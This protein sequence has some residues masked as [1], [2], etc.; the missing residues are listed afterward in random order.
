MF[1]RFKHKD[2]I[3]KNKGELLL[4]QAFDSKD[5][6]RRLRIRRAKES[7]HT[8]DYRYLLNISYDDKNW[9]DFI[10]TYSFM[11]VQVTGRNLQNII[12]G[13]ENNGI[14]LIQEFDGTVFSQ[15]EP[16]EAFIESIEII[17][18]Q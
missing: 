10:L 12:L 8:P 16:D 4:Y 1:E 13:I 3:N 6:S 7:A 18:K 11:Q 5:R 15:P 17:A 2:T 14:G 9:S